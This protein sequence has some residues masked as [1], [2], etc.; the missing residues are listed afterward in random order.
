[1][2]KRSNGN[3]GD[4][5]RIKCQRSNVMGM[6]IVVAVAV[7]VVVAV[8]IAV[9]IVVAVAVAAAVAAVAVAA[10]TVVTAAAAAAAAAAATATAVKPAILLIMDLL[11]VLIG[12]II[13][14]VL[15][16]VMMIESTMVLIIMVRV[17]FH[18]TIDSRISCDNCS[19]VEMMV[20]GN[21]SDN[22]RRTMAAMVVAIVVAT[23]AI[24]NKSDW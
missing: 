20:F 4:N 14:I 17:L 11:V 2:K 15:S 18:N 8:V 21:A 1:M 10:A 9:A 19:A 6:A 22:S 23:I 3:K 5:R 16:G 13:T 7:A 12:L 24:M